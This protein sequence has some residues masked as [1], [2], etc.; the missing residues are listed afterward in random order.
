MGVIGGLLPAGSSPDCIVEFVT[1]DVARYF[2][3]DYLALVRTA[4]NATD[5]LNGV[6]VAEVKNDLNR[7]I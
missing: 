7:P 5:T 4:C 1:I 3:H 2:F 6:G